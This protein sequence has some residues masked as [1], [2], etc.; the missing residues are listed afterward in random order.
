MFRETSPVPFCMAQEFAM[1]YDT[2]WHIQ[3]R[4]CRT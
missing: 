3:G 4:S 2:L 1:L